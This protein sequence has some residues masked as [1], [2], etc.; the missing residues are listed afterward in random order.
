MNIEDLME[1]MICDRIEMLM[2][3]RPE[4]SKNRDMEL[5]QCQEGITK[6]L[7]EE[8]R[9]KIDCLL[10]ELTTQ[11]GE[12]NRYLYLAGMNDGIRIAKLVLRT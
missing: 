6:E 11:F 5:F 7:D 10:D 2:K 1:Q 8:T 3:N 4:K 9:A 12:D